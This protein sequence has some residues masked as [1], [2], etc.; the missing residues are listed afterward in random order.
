MPVGP[1][2]WW[3]LEAPARSTLGPPA[4]GCSSERLVERIAIAEHVVALSPALT[5]KQVCRGVG[6]TA[7]ALTRH[8][9]VASQNRAKGWV[10]CNMIELGCVTRNIH[11]CPFF[12][13]ASQNLGAVSVFYSRQVKSS[14]YL[15]AS[16]RLKESPS[17]QRSNGSCLLLLPAHTVVL[18]PVPC[19]Q[20]VR[21]GFDRS[22]LDL[23]PRARSHSA[24][25]TVR[26]GGSLECR[27]HRCLISSL[28]H[29]VVLLRTEAECHC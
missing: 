21:W 7:S 19:G 29:A 13:G 9:V 15:L 20:E 27:S 11:A 26:T 4:I 25:S 10:R 28:K 6:G 12:A 17:N 2:R 8:A 22:V 3:H 5:N 1:P 23:L 18:S 14:G 24:P 16:Q